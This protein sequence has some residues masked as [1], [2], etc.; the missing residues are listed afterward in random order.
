MATQED[1]RRIALSLP[2]TSEHPDRFQFSVGGRHFAWAWLERVDPKRARVPSA[3]VIAVSVADE[4]EKQTV[5]SIDPEVFFTEPHYDGYPAV[6]VRLPEIDLDLLEIVITDAWRCRAPRRLAAA[7]EA[8][9]DLRP[10][11]ST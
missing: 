9:R 10:S 6:L 2:E 5:L 4:V 3:D 1:V 7:H 8:P 11:A